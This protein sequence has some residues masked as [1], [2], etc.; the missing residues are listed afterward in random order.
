MTN[1]KSYKIYLGSSGSFQIKLNEPC[2]CLVALADFHIP[3]INQHGFDE[4]GIEISCDQIDSTFDNPRRILKRLPFNRINKD[5]HFNSWEA[6]WLDFK[7]IDSADTFLDFSIKRLN[8]QTVRINKSVKD[9]FIYLTLAF[10]PINDQNLRWN[11][12]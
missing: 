9:R 11:A 1:F 7:T 10:K 6:K 8:K 3:N 5:D 12:I 4:N 2:N